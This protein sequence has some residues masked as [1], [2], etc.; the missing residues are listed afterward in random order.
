VALTKRVNGGDF[1]LQDR[2]N[3]TQKALKVLG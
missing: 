2:I 1:G 3:F